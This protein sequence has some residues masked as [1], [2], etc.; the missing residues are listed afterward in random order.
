MKK[1][2]LALLITILFISCKSIKE[3]QYTGIKGFKVNKID[4]KGI[5]ATIDLGIK[6]PND[7]GFSIYKSSFE[8]KVGGKVLG[9]AKSTK[10]VF[11]K[12]NEEKIY[13]FQLKSSFEGL[14]LGDIIKLVGGGAKGNMELKGKL[15]VGRFYIKKGFPINLSERIK[16]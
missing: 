5:D 1:L 14:E 2:C 4:L 7:Y 12:R 13:S 15:M 9:N 8:V 6:N 11:I 10:R 3:P 16:L